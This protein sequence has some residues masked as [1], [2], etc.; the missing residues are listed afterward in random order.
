MKEI[1]KPVFTDKELAE[2]ENGDLDIG[3]TTPGQIPL[4]PDFQTKPFAN[5]RSQRFVAVKE[6]L[7]GTEKKRKMHQEINKFGFATLHGWG[8]FS[9]GAKL[10][11]GVKYSSSRGL[12]KTGESVI[13]KYNQL[14]G[15]YLQQVGW[16]DISV[17]TDTIGKGQYIIP[18]NNPENIKLLYT[19]SPSIGFHYKSDRP[20]LETLRSLELGYQYEQ[21]LN[22]EKTR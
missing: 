19:L 14:L 17:E 1:A 10:V 7:N 18:L 15:Y 22:S 3:Y 21:K 4:G 12:T 20:D 2:I 6:K 8:K 11:F 9:D 16:K 5:K 13:K